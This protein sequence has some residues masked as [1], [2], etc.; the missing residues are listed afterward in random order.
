MEIPSLLL[1]NAHQAL[2]KLKYDATCTVGGHTGTTT[3]TGGLTLDVLSMSL[4]RDTWSVNIAADR[5][6]ISGDG[7]QTQLGPE[8]VSGGWTPKIEPN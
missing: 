6:T 5:L 2:G 1:S 8:H 7:R 4:A 3:Q